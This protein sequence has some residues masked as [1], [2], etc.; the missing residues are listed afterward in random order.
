MER[1]IREL[2][3]RGTL[4]G[5]SLRQAVGVLGGRNIGTGAEVGGDGV[6]VPILGGE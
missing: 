5:R 3:Y 2:R 4:L 1:D 6:K